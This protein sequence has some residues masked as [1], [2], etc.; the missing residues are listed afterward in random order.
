MPAAERGRLNRETAGLLASAADVLDSDQVTHYE[1][2]WLYLR[3][4]SER[5]ERIERVVLRIERG[6]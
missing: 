2:L 6:K 4:L 5:V 1:A 3:A